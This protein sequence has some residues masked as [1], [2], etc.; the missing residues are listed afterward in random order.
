MHHPT[1]WLERK[2][3]HLIS[4]EDYVSKLEQGHDLVLLD[5]RTKEEFEE[6]HIKDAILFP[7]L[8]VEPYIETYFPDK[9]KTYILYCRSG[10]RS[11]HALQSMRALG[12]AHVYD[13]GGIIDFTYKD[14]LIIQTHI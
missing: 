4:Q 9:Q 7:V 2:N 5:V 13:L 1:A 6:R 14:L 3:Q 12:Y 11:Q 10:V 8:Y